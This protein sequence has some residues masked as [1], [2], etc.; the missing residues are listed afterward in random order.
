MRGVVGRTRSKWP[1]PLTLNAL[2][3]PCPLRDARRR[4]ECSTG[5]WMLPND[6]SFHLGRISPTLSLACPVGSCIV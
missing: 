4:A 6:T 2:M 1:L 5:D 3:Q